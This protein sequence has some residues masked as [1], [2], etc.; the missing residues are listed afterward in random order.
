[1]KKLIS[2]LALVLVLFSLV[3]TKKQEK[4]NIDKPNIIYIMADDLGYGD[5]GCYGQK[6][7]KT[8]NLDKMASEGLRFTN[9]YSG[10]TVC[11]P[12]RYA[13]MSGQHMGH[14]YL[15]GNLEY[16][17]RADEQT[18]P[19]AMQSN[20]YITGMYGKWGLGQPNTEG[21]PE[22]QGWNEFLGYTKNQH[23]HRYY[24]NNLW[25]IKDNACVKFPMDSLQHSHP[26]IT[27]AAFDFIKS[28]KHKPFFMYWAM[29]IPHAEMYAPK[30]TLK[31]YL[32]PDGSSIFEEK[33]P[34]K[35]NPNAL[36]YR[37]Q[38]KANANTAAMIDH[39]DGDI[40]RLMVLL[41]ELGLDKNTYVFFTSDNGPHNEGGRDMAFFDSNGELRGFKRDLYEGGIRVPMIAWGAK[42][43]KGKETNQTWANWDVFP[44]LVELA[45]AETP[46]NIDGLSFSN[47]L[48]GKKA[49]RKHDY[50]YWE[51]FENGFDQAIRKGNWK[52][53]RK[54]SNANKMELYD[55][56]KDIAENNDLAN[57]YPKIATEMAKI[58][59][60]ARI[61][62]DL[63]K[64]KK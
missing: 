45:K 14:A 30:E 1:M 32:K 5:L 64:A 8:P 40:G 53:V 47:T 63:F 41:K 58:M 10:S 35:Q 37:S 52:A 11:T 28:H 57:K 36:S 27:D 38:D 62:S 34:F 42:V 51:F 39:L 33:K 6:I 46:K 24:T 48:H 21:S 54:S 16:P 19:K 23:A 13:L 7:I 22:K 4:L 61:E 50:L 31:K 59:S 17:M 26:V 55:L 44:T 43:P 3:S 29:A 20:G 15:R 25:T 56:S 12:S 60:E 9:F 49:I 2:N 18:L